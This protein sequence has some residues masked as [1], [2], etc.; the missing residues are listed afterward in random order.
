MNN[1]IFILIVVIG[2]LYKW[3][4]KESFTNF[5]GYCRSNILQNKIGIQKK[6]TENIDL[7]GFEL[8]KK[9]SAYPRVKHCP[10]HMNIDSCAKLIKSNQFNY[11]I[12]IRPMD[13]FLEDS[14]K[15][16]IHVEELNHYPE[17]VDHLDTISR[18][19]YIL[20]IGNSS[21][22][23]FNA[24]RVLKTKGFFTNIYYLYDS[25]FK[26]LKKKLRTTKSIDQTK[27][28]NRWKYM[29]LCKPK[30]NYI[31]ARYN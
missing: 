4:N 8:C 23:A 16:S 5:M 27:C 26:E 21:K 12:D 7:Y 30:L 20:V 14:L 9:H 13:N 17:K 28:I 19:A 22:N 29:S 18:E 2:F 6:N 11:I 3:V 10:I 15:S 31:K 1:S 24:A 25:N